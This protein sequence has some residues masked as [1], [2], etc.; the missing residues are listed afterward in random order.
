ME[1]SWYRGVLGRQAGDVAIEDGIEGRK[2]AIGG[3]KRKELD[4]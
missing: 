1:R 2:W 4:R 3:E